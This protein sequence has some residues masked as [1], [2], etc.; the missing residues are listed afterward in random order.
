M[1][2]SPASLSLEPGL[3]GHKRADA[4]TAVPNLKLELADE[5]MALGYRFIV[6]ATLQNGGSGENLAALIDLIE[7]VVGHDAAPVRNAT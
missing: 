6:I 3:F 1:G 4:A 7:P 5:A 2:A